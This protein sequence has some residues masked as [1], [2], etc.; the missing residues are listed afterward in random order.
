MDQNRAELI[1]I[2]NESISAEYGALFVLP[3]H[4]AIVKDAELKQQLREI[5]QMELEHAEKTAQII[6]ALGG[7]PTVDFPNLRLGSNT[8]EILEIHLKGERQAIDIYTRAAAKCSEPNWREV[9][10][11]LKTEEEAHQRTIEAAL[12]RV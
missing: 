4:I 9:L 1:K 5:A 2:L 7:E 6:N 12:A 3:R 8:R 10:L 11:E